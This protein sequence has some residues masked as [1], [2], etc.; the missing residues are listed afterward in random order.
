MDTFLIKL[1]RLAEMAS[2][3]ADPALPD[4]GRIMAAVRGADV[5]DAD[6][7]APLSLGVLCAGAAAAAAVAVVVTLLA[8]TAWADI[9]NPVKALGALLEATDYLL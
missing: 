5:D 6:D 3:E 2:R 1:E 9:N 4:V 7:G 8:A